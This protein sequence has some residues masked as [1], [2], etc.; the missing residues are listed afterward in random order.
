MIFRN[1]E[2]M[3]RILDNLAWRF[4]PLFKEMKMKTWWHKDANG[5]QTRGGEFKQIGKLA[6]VTID[7]AGHMNVADQREGTL[8]LLK[9]WLQRQ[10]LEG[11]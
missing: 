9:R 4:G 5:F 10:S 6:L 2:G 8:D 3:V 11:P 1:S 7:E